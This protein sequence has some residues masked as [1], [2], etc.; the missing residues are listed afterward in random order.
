MPRSNLSRRRN[1]QRSL[2]RNL[3]TSFILYERLQTTPAKARLAT[4]AV[5][6][7]V[8]V[9]KRWRVTTDPGRRL[10]LIRQLIAATSDQLAVKK[11]TE[12]LAVRYQNRTS[13]YARWWRSEPRL[14]DGAPQRILK[15]IGEPVTPAVEPAPAVK[16][17]TRRATPSKTKED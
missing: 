1:H 15:L 5:D 7:L 4:S 2:V 9:A 6:R 11:L 3:A 12:V 10:A 14:G 17:K 16:Q 13:G 8:T